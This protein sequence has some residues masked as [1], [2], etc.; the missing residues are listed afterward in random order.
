MTYLIPDWFPD[1][2][3]GGAVEGLPRL[4]RQLLE[5][6]FEEGDEAVLVG[7][8]VHHDVQ[9]ATGHDLHTK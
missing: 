9:D 1:A 2:L 7:V 8:A 6:R 4:G 5:E 3:H